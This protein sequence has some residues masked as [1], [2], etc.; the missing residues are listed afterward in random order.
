VEQRPEWADEDDTDHDAIIA[1]TADAVTHMIMSQDESHRFNEGS[2]H[3]VQYEARLNAP[4][5]EDVW[6]E[7]RIASP[8]FPPSA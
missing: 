2:R 7:P 5:P 4:I 8:G 1:F 3:H 6:A